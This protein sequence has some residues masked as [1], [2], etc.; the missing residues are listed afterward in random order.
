MIIGLG[1]LPKLSRPLRF[2]KM[3]NQLAYPFHLPEYYD[4]AASWLSDRLRSVVAPSLGDAGVMGKTP[5]AVLVPLVRRQAG[6]TVL[7][8]RRNDRLA[9]HPGQISFPGG[10][11]EAG[12]S[13]EL[14]ALR[15]THEEVGIQPDLIQPLGRIADY[16]TI[17]GYQVTPIIGLVSPDHRLSLQE[18]EVAEVFEVPVPF[19]LD[20][21]NYQRHP[22]EL[23]GRKGHY[24]SI[25]WQNRFI[26]GATA[27]MLMTLFTTLLDNPTPL[28]PPS[29][30]AA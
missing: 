19:L 10:R 8:T 13:P 18:D 12:E 9:K 1:I 23:P 24:L 2:D 25:T 16:F 7:F 30:E 28:Q 21:A 26:W 29:N 6:M 5:A 4:G 20:I 17:T 15:E 3:T 14:G 22:F 11:L 27:G